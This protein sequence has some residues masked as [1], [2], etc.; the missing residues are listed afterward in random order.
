MLQFLA[1]R[2]NSQCSRSSTQLIDEHSHHRSNHFLSLPLA[3]AP[4]N[5]NHSLIDYLKELWGSNALGKSGVIFVIGL[6]L[7]LLFSVLVVAVLSVFA[8]KHCKRKHEEPKSKAKDAENSLESSDALLGTGQ[9]MKELISLR[10]ESVISVSELD[11]E[12]SGSGKGT[13]DSAIRVWVALIRLNV[14]HSQF[15]TL[16]K[17]NF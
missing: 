8:P 2:R 3:P 11:E 1:C 5:R 16:E 13:V 7:L 10:K 9:S 4:D 6:L 14:S 12:D 15:G 17:R